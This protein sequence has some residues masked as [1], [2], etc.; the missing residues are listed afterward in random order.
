MRWCGSN[1]R[2]VPSCAHCISGAILHGG[3]NVVPLPGTLHHRSC[4]LL[5]TLSC[6][7]RHITWK[8]VRGGNTSLAPVPHTGWKIG[9]GACAR[10]SVY[11]SKCVSQV[12]L[13]WHS[14][15]RISC[16]CGEATLVM[17]QVTTSY[18]QGG[19]NVVHVQGVRQCWWCYEHYYT[20]TSTSH[21]NS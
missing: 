11:D 7:Q 4:F 1:S 6:Q 5:W 2:Y 13:H 8:I 19:S 21:G 9:Y 20:S 15:Q 18:H 16:C 14:L 17:C 3:S 10:D 12:V